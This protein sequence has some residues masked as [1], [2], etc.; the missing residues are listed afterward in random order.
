M[1]GFDAGRRPAG[2][3]PEDPAGA[4]PGV[5]GEAGA[6]AGGRGAGVAGGA[7]AGAGGAG[8]GERRK[9]SRADSLRLSRI[10]P[11]PVRQSA[12]PASRGTSAGFAAFG[13]TSEPAEPG[14][15]VPS[16]RSG[17]GGGTVSDGP[18]PRPAPAGAPAA[19]QPRVGRR[20]RGWIAAATVL[21]LA[22]LVGLVPA[23]RWM[24]GDKPADDAAAV[25]PPAPAIGSALPETAATPSA[26]PSEAAAAPSAAASSAPVPPAGSPSAGVASTTAAARTSPPVTGKANPAG[27]NLALQGAATASA[28]EG[29]PWLPRF[30]CD[31]DP[32]S[33]W[34]SAFSDPQWIKVDLRQRWQLTE[35]KLVW[36]RAYGVR[37]RIDT[38]L[39]GKSWRTLWSTASGRGGTV[40]VDARG[41]VARYVRMFGTQRSGQYGYSLLELEIR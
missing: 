38:S 24:T 29:D 28:A 27:A 12:D 40:P 16:M 8:V 39:D 13:T 20:R 11:R 7:G 32:S 35:V 4:G 36:E 30:A 15:S 2:G 33:R 19:A 10:P 26:A 21:A 31:G 23:Y 22:L 9:P 34:S 14:F 5:A 3:E 18:A 37:Y 1:D 6:G 17:A 25:A 41:T